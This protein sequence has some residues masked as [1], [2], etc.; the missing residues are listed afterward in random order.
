MTK[1]NGADDLIKTIKDTFRGR[2]HPAGWPFIMI[3]A[4]V[5]IVLAIVDEAL[6]MTGLILTGWCL[7][8]FRDPERA[9]PVREGLVVS[10]ANGRVV[11]IVPDQKLPPELT[12]AMDNLPSF[13]RISI[14]LNVFNVHVNRIPVDGVVVQKSYRPGKFLN[15]ALDKASEDNEM[16]ATLM[17]IQHKGK[18]HD[19]AVVQIA[20][21]VARRIINETKEDMVMKAGQRMGIIRFGSRTDIYIPEDVV[22]RV[23]VGQTVIEGETIVAD[24]ANADTTTYVAEVR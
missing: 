12:R 9:T 21:W 14:F 19:F 5:T 11:A 2:I 17:K 6:G 23:V 18:D 15:A 1:A 13:T 20:G 10:P 4:F 8:F 22:P 7:Y 24:L 3:F 16:S